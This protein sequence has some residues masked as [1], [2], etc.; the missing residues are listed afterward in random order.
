MRQGHSRPRAAPRRHRASAAAPR[1]AGRP[2]AA[3]RPHSAAAAARLEDGKRVEV[4]DRSHAVL[5]VP[6]RREG[7][8]EGPWPSA[9]TGRETL[10]LAPA[11]HPAAAAA[12]QAPGPSP[13]LP[14]SPQSA[15]APE[16]EGPEGPG[17]Q[18]AVAEGA[19]QPLAKRLL[20]LA[21]AAALAGPRLDHLRVGREGV[22]SSSMAGAQQ[23]R[24]TR[25]GSS[26]EAASLAARQA[27]PPACK[28]QPPCPPRRRRL[29]C[30]P[31]CRE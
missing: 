10:A 20:A 13:R 27:A 28:P 7:G 6:A 16:D 21:L 25:K 31:A 11:A 24:A 3:G 14:A 1:Q 5:H 4:L 19:P 22:V 17:Q 9:V 26:E 30:R 8:R 15:G 12:G 2:H 18:H 23:Q 29:R